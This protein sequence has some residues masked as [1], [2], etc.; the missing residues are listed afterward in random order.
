MTDSKPSKKHLRNIYENL[1]T[2]SL[3][4][5]RHEEALYYAEQYVSMFSENENNLGLLNFNNNEVHNKPDSHKNVS[6]NLDEL[7]NK[8]PLSKEN[9]ISDTLDQD[10]RSLYWLVYC[11]WSINKLD[12]VYKLFRVPINIMYS[13]IDSLLNTEIDDIENRKAKDTTSKL[14]E[15]LGISTELITSSVWIY[16]NS[17]L[18]IGMYNESEKFTFK[19]LALMKKTKTILETDLQDETFIPS[20]NGRLIL[21]QISSIYYTLGQI[22]LKTSRESKAIKWYELAIK[23]NPFCNSAW[24][25]LC[26]LRSGHSKLDEY[27][28]YFTKFKEDFQT[29]NLPSSIN[30]TIESSEIKNN[31]TKTVEK[32]ISKSMLKPPSQLNNNTI[33][34]VLIQTKIT[35]TSVFKRKATEISSSKPNSFGQPPQSY[36]NKKPNLPIGASFKKMKLG[37]FDPSERSKPRKNIIKD[38]K[39]HENV[40]PYK[41]DCLDTYSSLLWQKKDLMGLKSLCTTMKSKTLKKSVDL[42]VALANLFSL[43]KHHMLSL[44]ALYNGLQ[45][46]LYGFAV[47]RTDINELVLF[48]HISDKNDLEADIET[49][50]EN[51]FKLTALL[52]KR[53]QTIEALQKISYVFSLVGYEFT[54]LEEFEYAV[55]AF[56][57]SIRI[58]KHQYNPYY[59]LGMLYLR[60]KKYDL[61]KHYLENALNLN[62]VNPMLSCCLAMLYEEMGEFNTSYKYY[63][64]SVVRSTFGENVE[65]R[66]HVDYENGFI[67]F[68]LFKIAN[69][70]F[71]QSQFAKAK[72]ILLD[73]F[74]TTSSS[75]EFGISNDEILFL[76]GQTLSNLGANN[77]ANMCFQQSLLYLDS[78]STDVNL[79]MF[80]QNLRTV[81]SKH[82]D[83]LPEKTY[84]DSNNSKTEESE[85]TSKSRGDLSA[86]IE[87]NKLRALTKHVNIKASSTEVWAPFWMLPETSHDVF[88]LITAKDILRIRN[89]C[90]ENFAML[91]FKVF[92]KLREL[93]AQK[94]VCRDKLLKKQLLNCIRVLTRLTPYIY[95]TGNSKLEDFIFWGIKSR[96]QEL[97]DTECAKMSNIGYELSEIS[98]RLMFMSGLT[99]SEH[100][101][102]PSNNSLLAS[103]GNID[104]DTANLENQDPLTTYPIWSE[105]IGVSKPSP[106]TLNSTYDIFSNRAEVIQL[107]LVI[108]S[109][110]IYF[111]PQVV[112]S[113][114]NK[115]LDHMT[116]HSDD[117]LLL[118]LLSSLI[119]TTLKIHGTKMFR[120]SYKTEFGNLGIESLVSIYS[121]QLLSV[122][123]GYPGVR[124]PQ[125]NKMY[126][127]IS[128]LHRNQD[129]DFII[130][131]SV[132]MLNSA[133][134][135]SQSIIATVTQ[136]QNNYIELSSSVILILF[137]IS[138][139]NKK[140]ASYLGDHNEAMNFFVLLSSLLLVYKGNSVHVSFCKFISFLIHKLSENS[141]FAIR[142]M[143]PF[144]DRLSTVPIHLLPHKNSIISVNRRKSE[145][146]TPS[147][148]MKSDENILTANHNNDSLEN[149]VNIIDTNKNNENSDN[150]TNG[151]Q[152]DKIVKENENLIND[153]GNDNMPYDNDDTSNIISNYVDFFIQ[154]TYSMISESNHLLKPVYSDL[155]VAIRNLSPFITNV[156]VY[157]T[158]CLFLMFDVFS[159]PAFM[160]IDKLHVQWLSYILEIFNYIIHYHLSDSPY[161]VYQLLKYTDLLRRLTKFDYEE[162]MSLL[163]NLKKNKEQADSKRNILGKNELTTSRTE[164]LSPESQ[165]SLTNSKLSSV[166][167]NLHDIDPKGKSREDDHLGKG[168]GKSPET[169]ASIKSDTATIS[170]TKERTNYFRQ[171]SLTAA[172]KEWLM[173]YLE[174]L[175]TNSIIS[176]L[177]SLAPHVEKIKSDASQKG[178][179]EAYQT[180]LVLSFLSDEN[181]INFIPYSHTDINQ[182]K[183]KPNP[184][185]LNLYKNI[186]FLAYFKTE[187]WS[188]IFITFSKPLGLFN[189]SNIKLFV[190]KQSN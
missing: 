7:E 172:P 142:M 110:D 82:S 97:L 162:A 30:N 86:D 94:Y 79:S 139:C 149:T 36:K 6:V 107:L 2:N 116:N 17:C 49:L 8:N 57:T 153:D 56:T 41:M 23:H 78:R 67:R 89:T 124:K 127:F 28:S 42:Y 69:L 177:S 145:I 22:H 90:P 168:K 173:P 26:L 159:S 180:S 126:N 59:G 174:T 132:H 136:T 33:Q 70:Y 72:K 154:Y 140:F 73:L 76:L 129:F 66:N 65:L 31:V 147:Q 83:E 178:E 61:S 51:I 138:D 120:T 98:M 81:I 54:N 146:Q 108:A 20:R 119:N 137:Q 29:R 21:P 64:L 44:L 63:K 187:T 48:D 103:N 4:Q 95:E 175:K 151:N 104:S 68:V 102:V 122:F 130:K 163:V 181:V 16:L 47:D 167:S 156:S 45:V 18:L 165:T 5:F 99:V 37:E 134:S 50:A 125:S 39:D 114:E 9:F 189:G 74:S 150:H 118:S 88:S 158:K 160:I 148:T 77:A 75:H 144:S 80:A 101:N 106:T 133:L 115:A 92:E 176:V 185:E 60:S 105:G 100:T 32:R 34:R 113:V 55:N 131:N 12:I 43:K 141:S 11:Y 10:F 3:D 170:E 157:T 35:N 112:V 85:Q 93:N 14:E 91:Y 53:C 52:I 84:P 1:I 27:R 143:Q 190:V 152:D 171:I 87:N 24:K 169:I 166:A 109:K 188:R 161:F 13:K 164:S 71:K 62:S 96:Y 15:S 111:K 46:E 135:N 155:L 128:M 117:Q 38:D 19:I 182:E 183:P 40:S 179:S 25:A 58:F 186:M 123:L 121:A 184:K